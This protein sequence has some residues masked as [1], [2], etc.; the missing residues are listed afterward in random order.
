MDK[1][2]LNQVSYKI[3][4]FLKKVKILICLF[5]AIINL[6]CNDN[7]EFDQK[8]FEVSDITEKLIEKNEINQAYTILIKYK[9]DLIKNSG[10]EIREKCISNLIYTF[11]NSL[12]E[13]LDFIDQCLKVEKKRKGIFYYYLMHEKSKCLADLNFRNASLAYARLAYQKSFDY[14]KSIWKKKIQLGYA[15]T[16]LSESMYPLDSIAIKRFLIDNIY[17]NDDYFAQAKLIEI[18]LRGMDVSQLDCNT[19]DFLFENKKFNSKTKKFLYTQAGWISH[20]YNNAIFWHSQNLTNSNDICN[21]SFYSY[22]YCVEAMIFNN[23]FQDALTLMKRA[24]NICSLKSREKQYMISRLNFLFHK[25]NYKLY[26][27][28]EDLKKALHFSL[29]GREISK[30]FSVD[31]SIHLADYLYESQIEIMESLYQLYNIKKLDEKILLENLD[32]GKYLSINMINTNT[33]FISKENNS[34]DTYLDIQKEIDKLELKINYYTDTSNCCPEV[35]EALCELYAK[36]IS[37]EGTSTNINQKINHNIDPNAIKQKLK[38]DNAQ[39]IDF[40][41]NDSLIYVSSINPIEVKIQKF[42]INNIRQKIFNIKSK[43]RSKEKIESPNILDTIFKQ[44][45]HKNYPMVF[46]SADLELGLFP[47]DVLSSPFNESIINNYQINYVANIAQYLLNGHSLIDRKGYIHKQKINKKSDAAPLPFL[48][49]EINNIKTSCRNIDFKID[50]DFNDRLYKKSAF[51]SSLV[52][53]AGHS[54]SEPSRL[55]DNYILT[56]DNK[57]LYGFEIRNIRFN[58]SPIVVLSSCDSGV[59]VVQPGAGTFS[60]SRDFFA[61]GAQT[62]IKSLWPVNDISTYYLMSDFYTQLCS[63][64]NASESLW[65]AKKKLKQNKKFDKPYYWAGFVIEGNGFVYLEK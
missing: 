6:G 34:I 48:E 8:L 24:S 46:V 58:H 16:L 44:V 62:V 5:T 61:A 30:D 11:E 42:K 56:G 28:V 38:K 52:H 27:K 55:F 17:D 26:H 35:Y 51:G 23:Q 45:L 32:Y 15:F 41:I 21:I 4:F 57:K 43:L 19:Y 29:E 18:G 14:V 53:F 63:G 40:I 31:N 7:K 37:L 1:I 10:G 20:D 59:G 36:K 50:S 25:Q 2:I 13:K 49:K 9:D 3:L 12:N 33:N 60:L 65:H 22:V 47:I 54:Y 39:F 64:K